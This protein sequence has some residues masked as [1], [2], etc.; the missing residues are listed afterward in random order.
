MKANDKL[1]A[2]VRAHLDA[3]QELKADLDLNYEVVQETGR[4]AYKDEK[5]DSS[6][7]DDDYTYNSAGQGREVRKHDEGMVLMKNL[8]RHYGMSA[9]CDPRELEAR[10]RLEGIV[11]DVHGI[12]ETLDDELGE[13]SLS[14]KR[15]LNQET[16]RAKQAVKTLSSL[17]TFFRHALREV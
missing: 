3:I 12:I 1:H 2:S 8:R 4:L 10:K 9:S 11:E 14:G 6:D 5:S 13:E 7:E 17:T 16:S 15:T